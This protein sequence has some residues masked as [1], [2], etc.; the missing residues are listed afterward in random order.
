MPEGP[1]LP[2][3]REAGSFPEAEHSKEKAW[4]SGPEG[5]SAGVRRSTLRGFIDSIQVVAA[6]KIKLAA[7]P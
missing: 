4:Q 2:G 3:I 1:G 5:V 6:K 7:L